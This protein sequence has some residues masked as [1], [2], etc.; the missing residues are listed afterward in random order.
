MKLRPYNPNNDFEYLKK[1]IN[2]E[3]IHAFWCANL[4]PY[5]ITI[6]SFHT[7]L[8]KLLMNQAN[9]AYVATTTND[10]PIGFFCYSINTEDNTGFLKFVI[11]DNTK[12]GS[13][14]G[15]KMLLQALQYAFN[16]TGV[17]LVQLNV[18]NENSLAK[19]CYEKIGFTER[20]VDKNI[21]RYENELWSRCNMIIS[22]HQLLA[23]IQHL[24][25]E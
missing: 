14:Y 5:P 22:K 24:E 10:Q 12:R 7:F 1:W 3:K 2:N 16:T 19:H 18:F 17:R 11:V 15:S 20:Y 21:F 13:G 23:K 25:L 4:L 9:I 8:E 6:N